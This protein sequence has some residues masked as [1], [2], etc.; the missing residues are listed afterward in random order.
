MASA[1]PHLL[2]IPNEIRH[3]IL[4]YVFETG[5][6]TL[7]RCLQVSRSLP[8]TMKS[9]SSACI[10]PFDRPSFQPDIIRVLCAIQNKTII[11]VCHQLRDEVVS[12]SLLS[13]AP[14]PR[15]LVCS[16]FCLMV[17]L[18]SPRCT[19]QHLTRM[20]S[21]KM[22]K[23]VHLIKSFF[24]GYVNSERFPYAVSLEL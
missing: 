7:C 16:G 22:L 12:D 9:N 20:S 15:I 21:F 6:I 19:S 8:L 2:S 10:C 5:S 14:S 11:Q 13:G 4:R 18:D 24:C 17:L 23:P 3:L 1:K